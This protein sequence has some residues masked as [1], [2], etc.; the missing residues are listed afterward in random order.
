M[1]L[2]ALASIAALFGFFLMGDRLN[3]AGIAGCALIFASTMGVQL[4]PMLLRQ[5]NR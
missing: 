2:F 4:L 3:G 5:R 1:R